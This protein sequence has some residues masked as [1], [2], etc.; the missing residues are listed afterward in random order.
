MLAERRELQL[1]R[2]RALQLTIGDHHG[3]AIQDVIV[4]TSPLRNGELDVSGDDHNGVAVNRVPAID[5][6]IR[7]DHVKHV[8]EDARHKAF[9]GCR[10][11]L[12]AA[13]ADRVVREV[14]IFE[15]VAYMTRIL[16][17]G[18]GPA[19]HLLDLE[20]RGPVR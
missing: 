20:E 19:G 7:I 9:G 3:A 18:V 13:R 2:T 17:R 16:L 4:Q 15:H 12:L 8:S 5:R 14:E 6:G 11:R 10:Q 1:Q